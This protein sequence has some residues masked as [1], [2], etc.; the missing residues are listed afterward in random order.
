MGFDLQELRAAVASHG[1]VTRVVIA[2]IRGSSPREVG[3]AMLVWETGQSG[4]IGGGAL[5]YEAA[6][7]SRRQGAK[8][9]L[10]THAL[11]PDLGQCCGG[12]VTLLRETYKAAD[13]EQLDA[14]IIARPV[15]QTASPKEP[16]AVKRLLAQLRNQGQ[17]P[18]P[19]LI[20]GWMV[21]PVHLPQTDLWIWGAG[22]VGRA[23]VDVLAPLPD[24][25][26]TWVDT[27]PARFPDH[28][29][30]QVTRLPGADP[31]LLLRHAPVNAQHLILTYSHELDLALCH[32]LLLHGFTFAGLIGSATKW[33]RFRS[34]LA[35]LGHGPAEIARITCPI[36]SPALGKHPQMIAVGV[37]AQLLAQTA[38]KDIKEERRA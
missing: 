19:Q 4:T 18:D 16:L 7:I 34:R 29:P 17:R 27:A 1:R 28:I 3:A 2:A 37:A 24:L 6:Q 15:A 38:I 26:I 13:L 23:L 21:E 10:S 33:A 5:E 30:P 11:G 35:A 20:E 31:V 8:S 22:H 36:G 25:S 12:S 14:Q 32:A 9:G